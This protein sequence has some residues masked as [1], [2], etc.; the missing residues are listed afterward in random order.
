MSPCS[1]PA[2][3]AP[4]KDGTMKICVDIHAIDNIIIKYRYA[5]PRL[6]DMLDE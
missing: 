1:T 2:L 4:K 5:I 3:L 6:N